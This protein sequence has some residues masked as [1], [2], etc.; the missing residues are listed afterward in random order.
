MFVILSDRTMLNVFCVRRIG[1]GEIEMSNGDVW[2][3]NDKDTQAVMDTMIKIKEI[4]D[5]V[6]QRCLT[7]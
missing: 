6:F 7:A 5:H 1:D 3:M 2:P 4:A